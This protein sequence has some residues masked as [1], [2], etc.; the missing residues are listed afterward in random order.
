LFH[1]W[2]ILATMLLTQACSAGM[3]VYGFGVIQVP[4]AEEFGVSRSAVSLTVSGGMLCG[5]ILAPGMGRAIDRGPIRRVM[6]VCAALMALGYVSMSLAQSLPL[7]LVLYAL[8]SAVAIQGLGNLVASKLM[9]SWFDRYRGRTLGGVALGT[10]IG[11]LLL[12][13]MLAEGVTR[14]GWRATMAVAASTIFVLVC[15][16][17]LSTIRDHPRDLGLHPDGAQ[18]A[19][20]VGSLGRETLVW[21]TAA[22]LREPGFLSLA[23]VLGVMMATTGSLIAHLPPIAMELGLAPTPAAALLSILS[24]AAIVGKL[25]FGFAAERVDKRLLLL[26]ASALL[27]GF[28]SLLASEPPPAWLAAGAVLPGLA[29]GGILPLWGAILGDYYGNES[30]A[31]AMGLMMPVTVA[32]QIAAMQL[33]PWVY[34]QYGSYTP[35]FRIMLFAF[36]LVLLAMTRLRRP[37]A[38][39]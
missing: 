34:D 26:L 1:G 7:V 37:V 3:F 35:A 28:V 31:G 6:L 12:P 29:L 32:A 19:P 27:A 18:D 15:V 39:A 17:I 2:K 13:P 16:P 14:F 38:P 23:I 21:S 8:S 10:S 33:V 9:G 22:L 24:V 4:I 25:V 30:M 36:V 5:A 20:S 11:G